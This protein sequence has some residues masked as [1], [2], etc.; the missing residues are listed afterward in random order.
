[1]QIIFFTHFSTIREN[2]QDKK[3]YQLKAIVTQNLLQNTVMHNQN[4]DFLV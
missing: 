4:L 1:M 2:G 3:V